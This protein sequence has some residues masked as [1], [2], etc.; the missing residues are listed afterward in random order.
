MNRRE[1]IQAA[2]AAV[3]T[4]GVEVD[5][6]EIA[7]EPDSEPVAFVVRYKGLLDNRQRENIYN[8]AKSAFA[9]TQW[10]SVPV[11][12]CDAQFDFDLMRVPK[13]MLP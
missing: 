3:A 13:E 8:S 9:A 2:V 12:V 7:V 1:A 5:A 4:G 6:K 10:A 11:L